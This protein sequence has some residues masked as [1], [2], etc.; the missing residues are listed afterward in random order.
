M[1]GIDVQAGVGLKSIHIHNIELNVLQPDLHKVF[2][3]REKG[4]L[5]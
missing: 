3:S 1:P 5:L 4:G 2:E